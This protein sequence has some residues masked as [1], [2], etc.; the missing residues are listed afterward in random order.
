MDRHEVWCA[1]EQNECD[2]GFQQYM[3]VGDVNFMND[4]D[5]HRV[6]VHKDIHGEW[7]WTRRD[8]DN[9]VI[10]VS[11]MRFKN[12]RLAMKHAKQMNPNVKIVVE[13]L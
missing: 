11:S 10:K 3:T 7:V 4:I 2:C 12:V 1:T 13:G 6:L 5:Q 9:V 8:E